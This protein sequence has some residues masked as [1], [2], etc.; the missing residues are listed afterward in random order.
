MYKNE[1]QLNKDCR[2]NVGNK[3]LPMDVVVYVL[4]QRFIG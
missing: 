4:Q 2:I 1:L 3:L